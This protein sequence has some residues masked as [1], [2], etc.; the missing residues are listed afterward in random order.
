MET[1]AGCLMNNWVELQETDLLWEPGEI[2]VN[3]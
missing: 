2:A 3:C 1:A